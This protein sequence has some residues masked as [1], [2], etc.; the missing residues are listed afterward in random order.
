M[1][2]TRQYVNLNRPDA[3]RGF[4]FFGMAAGSRYYQKA[5]LRQLLGKALAVLS[6]I[7][8][9]AEYEKL[10]YYRLLHGR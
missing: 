1:G 8:A 10:N 5:G 3:F 4:N 6:E 2:F 7:R 9:A